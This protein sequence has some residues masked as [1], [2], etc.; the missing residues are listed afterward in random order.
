MNCS[1][2]TLKHSAKNAHCVGVIIPFV[3]LADISWKK[4]K[5]TKTPFN[6][7][8]TFSQFKIMSLR[9]DDIMTTN[10]WKLH[11]KIIYYSNFEKRRASKRILKWSTI[12]L[13]TN[14]N[15]VH[16]NSNMIEMKGL[17]P[18]GEAYVRRSL[19]SWDVDKIVLIQKE[20]IN[21]FQQF[22]IIRTIERSFWLQRDVVH[23]HQESGKRKLSPVPF[24]K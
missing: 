18:D 17:C 5:P 24:W 9:R 11:K 8:L 16:L 6:V 23:L 2:Q 12:V 15:W 20:L 7:H 21:F 1:R 4:V 22:R 19:P 14:L 13:W 10:V 3:A